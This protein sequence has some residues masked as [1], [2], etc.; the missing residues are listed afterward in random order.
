MIHR[1]GRFMLIFTEYNGIAEV[2]MKDPDCTVPELKSE[3]GWKPIDDL[4]RIGGSRTFITGKENT[5]ILRLSYCSRDEDGAL[6]G[7]AWFGPGAEGPPQHAHGGAIAAVFDEIMGAAAWLAGYPILAA[8]VSV[9]FKKPVP[10]GKIIIYE[11]QVSKT[12]G[13]RVFVT[14]RMHAGKSEPYATGS[15]VFVLIDPEKIGNMRDRLEK[16]VK[17]AGISFK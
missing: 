8:R 16:I 6:V 13:R 4:S 3:P 12:E 2:P 7:K 14:A 11:A 5:H 1:T 15:G 10:L 17:Q 9:D